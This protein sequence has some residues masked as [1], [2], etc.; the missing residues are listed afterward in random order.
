MNKKVK[1]KV[2]KSK[3]KISPRSFTLRT[4]SDWPSN[5]MNPNEAIILSHL[6]TKWK[7]IARARNGDLVISTSKPKK[8]LY[9]KIWFTHDT[10]EWPLDDSVGFN[11]R[12]VQVFPYRNM[13]KFISWNDP[14]PRNID[15]LLQENLSWMV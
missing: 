11:G 5:L 1:K 8:Y 6:P 9:D 7:W 4:G 2:V 12:E 10:V 15:K 14:E 13:F 3:T